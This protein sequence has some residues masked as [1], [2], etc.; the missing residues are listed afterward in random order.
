MGNLE[1]TKDDF[2]SGILGR[3]CG[4]IFV[5][6]DLGASEDI[7]EISAANHIDTLVLFVRHT[8][9][10]I[11]VLFCGNF[12]YLTSKVKYRKQ[13]SRDTSPLPTLNEIPVLLMIFI[14]S[15]QRMMADV[16]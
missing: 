2:D 10:N 6:S 8:R 5:D 7:D 11:E 16:P 4:K 9:R 14:F 3:N 1:L 15:P 13:L 12:Q